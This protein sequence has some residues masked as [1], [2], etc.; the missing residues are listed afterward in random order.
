[1]PNHTLNF[2]WLVVTPN[3]CTHAHTYTC[4]HTHTQLIS[5]N[6]K[7]I[8]ITHTLAKW[9]SGSRKNKRKDLN[10]FRS[11]FFR[12]C[13]HLYKK[14]GLQ[15]QFKVVVDTLKVVP[16]V[17]HVDYVVAISGCMCSIAIRFSAMI[18]CHR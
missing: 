8:E 7:K 16:I 11:K 1:V 17:I 12:R 6:G 2:P 4:S 9:G 10:L 13:Q 14:F 15:R 18:F 3:L 5:R